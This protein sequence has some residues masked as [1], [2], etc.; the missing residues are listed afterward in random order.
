MWSSFTAIEGSFT[1][2]PCFAFLKAQMVRGLK[3]S[4]SL[5]QRTYYVAQLAVRTYKLA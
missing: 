1:L 2:F 5:S 4:P 3:L